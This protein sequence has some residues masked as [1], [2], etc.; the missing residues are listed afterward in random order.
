MDPLEQLSRLPFVARTRCRI[1][2]DL[3]TVIDIGDEDPSGSDVPGENVERVWE[4]ILEMYRSGVYP[5][6]QVSIR[7]RGTVVLDRTIGHARGNAPSDESDEPKVLATCDTPFDLFSASKAITAMVIHKLDEDGV[8]HLEDRVCDFIPDFAR[9]GKQHITLR[10]LLAHRAGMPNLPPESLDLDILGQPDKIMEILCDARLQ[11]R[12]GRM[13]AYHA[14]TGGFVLGEVVR[15][16]TGHDIRHVLREKI[17]DPMGLR[18]L[19]YGVRPEDVD[20]V[21]KDALTGPN[22]PAPISTFLR[23]ALG[24][25]LGQA[26]EIANDPRFL[27]GIVPSANIVATARETSA[28]YQCLLDE[29]VY[30]GK[31]IFQPATIRHARSEQSYWEM[32]LTLGL[33]LRYGLGFML[34]SKRMSLFGP[35]NAAAFGHVGFTNT[36]TWADP[37]RQ[38]AVAIVTNGKPVISLHAYALVQALREVAEAFPKQS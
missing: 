10:H 28:F 2:D 9:H 20:R 19:G 25:D 16:A 7:R 6:L 12:P 36:F 32:D 29:G 30:Q 15:C 26:V 4:R 23:S 11:T 5:A 3:D 8:L 13:L 22:P 38:I 17:S 1:P 21:A 18:W 37:E 14:V 33:P 24:V 34:G 27:T 35:D 31:Q